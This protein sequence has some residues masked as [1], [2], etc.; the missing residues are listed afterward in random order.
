MNHLQ[1]ANSQCELRS[2]P[3]DIDRVRLVL[4]IVSTVLIQENCKVTTVNYTDNLDL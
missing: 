3:H 2:E 4:N 1:T